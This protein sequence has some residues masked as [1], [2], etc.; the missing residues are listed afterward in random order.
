MCYSV[1][2][3]YLTIEGIFGGGGVFILNKAYRK[4]PA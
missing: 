4:M 1:N 2:L 3:D